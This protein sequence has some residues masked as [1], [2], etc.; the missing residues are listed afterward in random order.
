MILELKREVTATMTPICAPTPTAF[1]M[2]VFGME[3]LK[4]R[5]GR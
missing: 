1:L 3:K 5:E 4:I 2:D